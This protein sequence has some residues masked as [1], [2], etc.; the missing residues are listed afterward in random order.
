[1]KRKQYI[2]IILYCN[3][4]CNHFYHN[5]DDGE[6][7]WCERL[8]MKVAEAGPADVMN[9]YTARPIPEVCPLDDVVE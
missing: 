3:Q 6:N 4:S 5:F 7:C 1:M 9:D 2:Q 8:N